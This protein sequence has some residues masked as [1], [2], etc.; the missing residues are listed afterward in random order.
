[1]KEGDN[2]DNTENTAVG[3]SHFV[4]TESCINFHI[5]KDIK[6]MLLPR[7]QIL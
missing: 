7:N 2:E 1:M 5:K 6:V 4:G 3:A